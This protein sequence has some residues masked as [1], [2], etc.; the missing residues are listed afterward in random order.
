MRAESAKAKERK[1]FLRGQKMGRLYERR[2]SAGAITCEECGFELALASEDEDELLVA[3]SVFDTSHDVP[4]SHGTGYDERR[5]P[6]VGVDHPV[7]VTYLC[8]N[9]HMK[10]HPGPWPT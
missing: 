7:N 5:W 4:R 10:L 6:E 9:C 2:E 1:A 8:R 3:V